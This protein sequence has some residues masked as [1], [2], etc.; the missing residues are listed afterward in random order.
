MPSGRDSFRRNRVAPFVLLH[1]TMP[2]GATFPTIGGTVSISNSQ[3]AS[4]FALDQII[5]LYS[6]NARSKGEC[7]IIA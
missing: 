7:N 4:A 2:S 3:E 1:F 5:V 6:E